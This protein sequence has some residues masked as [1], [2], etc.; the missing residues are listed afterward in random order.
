MALTS[1]LNMTLS[2]L[3]TTELKTMVSSQNITNADKAG[4]TRKSVELQYI[5]TTSGSVPVE[6]LIV[7]S[8]DSFLLKALT[9]DV[10]EYS[11]KLSISNSLNYY[12]TQLG[13]TDGTNTLSSYLDDMYA[14]L[15]S[16]ATSPETDAN[17]A[18]V[19]S[20]AEGLSNTLRSLSSQIQDLR[21][22]AE[23]QIGSQITEANAI[24]DRLDELNDKIAGNPNND[25]SLAEYEDQRNQELLNLSALMGVQYFYTDGNILQLYTSNGQPLLLS[26]PHYINHTVTNSVNGSTTYPAGFD[27]IDLDGVDITT[28]ITG[29]SLEGLITLR[30]SFY[31]DE[32]AKLNELASVLQTQV[33]TLLNTGASVPPRNTMVGSLDALTGATAFTGTGSIRVAVLDQNGTV[34]NYS[35]ISLVGM[36]TVSDVLTSLNGVAGLTATLTADGKLSIVTAPTTSGVAINPLTSAVTSSSSESFAQYFGLNDLFIGTSA[37]DIQ[38]SSYLV[39]APQYLSVGVLS[40]SATLAA[41]DTGVNRGDGSIADS[42]ADILVGNSSFAAAG[43]FAAQS[44]SLQHYV[45]AFMSNAATQATISEGETETSYITYKASQDVLSSKS[46]VNVDEETAKMLIYQNQYEASAQVMSTIQ[47]MLNTLMDAMR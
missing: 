43:D 7:G 3:M 18:E 2:G 39:S 19:I 1:A 14:A 9:G 22:Q 29:G 32:Q 23:Q 12:S 28:R 11:A 5:T 38:V 15:Q 24:L 40:S 4:Y 21:L 31:T 30:D 42:V 17:K 41:G 6:G 8:G 37:E 27:A 26:D 47:E 34:T 10:A 20:M 13:N 36:T 44:T 25:S 33:N 46:G 16:L 35:D 45:Q